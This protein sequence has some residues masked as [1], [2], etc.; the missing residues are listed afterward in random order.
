MPRYKVNISEGVF[1]FVEAESPDEA[2]KKVKAEIAKG[3]IS[4]FYDKLFFDYDTGVNVEGIRGKLGRAETLEEQDKVITNLMDKVKKRKLPQEQEDLMQTE[5][6]SAGFVRNTKGQL[7]LTPE[8]LRELGLT[9]NTTELEDGSII[10]QNTVIDERDFGLRTGDLAD[11]S[12]VA[13]PII[14]MLALMSPHLK[15]FKG[16]TSLFGGRQVISRMFAAGAGSVAGKGAEEVL[17][18]RQGFQLQDRDELANLLGGE[19]ILGSAGQGLGEGVF[20]IY[21]TFLGKRASHSSQRMNYQTTQ[22]RSVMDV[23]NLD[24]SLGREA[25]EKEI[26]RAVRDGE[27]KEFNWELNKSTGAIPSQQT[28]KRLIPARGQGIAE[29][30]IGNNR[31]IPNQQFLFA[32]LNY[33]LKGI[34]DE[35]SSLTSYISKTTKGD[36][37]ESISNALQDLRI[38][39]QTV[40]QS[41][42]K[43]LDDVSVDALEI[44]NYHNVPSR[45]ATGLAIKE[46]LG[47]A[48]R[49]VMEEMGVKYRDVDNMF[50]TMRSNKEMVID[51]FG[52]MIPKLDRNGQEI[53]KEGMNL[54]K[55]SY[56]NQ[57][58]G[59]IMGGHLE[60]AQ[61]RVRTFKNRHPMYR[62]SAAD[63]ELSGGLINTLDASLE[64]M[65][66]QARTGKLTLDQIRNSY[67]KLREITSTTAAQSPERKLIYE[68]MDM[69]DDY[70]K[71]GNPG[72]KPNSILTD[73]AEN[74][75]AQF[76]LKLARV[77]KDLP[78]DQRIKLNVSEVNTLNK[79][80]GQLRSANKLNFE[81]SSPF[82]AIDMDKIIAN[83]KKG[84]FNADE[85]YQSVIL[86]GKANRL[87]GIFAGLRSYDDYLKRIGKGDEAIFEN[88]VKSQIKKRLFAD[89]F[90]K[91]T[92]NGLEE[93]NFVDFAREINRFEKSYPGKFDLLFTN[94]NTGRNTGA[95]VRDTINQINRISPNLKPEQMRDLANDFTGKN[96]G[97]NASDQGTAFIQGLR[98]LATESEKVLKF[99][100]NKAI[101]D[102]PDKGI[103]ET[104]N[105]IFRPGSA[106]SINLLK[107]TVS[108]EV[109]NSVQQASM[110]K[111]LAKSIDFNGEGKITDI[112]KEGN[113]SMALKSYGDETLD[114][115][116]G[117]ELTQGLKGF[118][119]TVDNL[120]SGEVGRGGAAGGLVAAGIGAAIILNPLATLPV[121]ASLGILRMVFSSPK[122][123]GLLT[124]TDSGSIQQLI[125]MLERA[126]R[127]AGFRMIDGEFVQSASSGISEGVNLIKSELGKSQEE[128]KSIMNEG[129]DVFDDLQNQATKAVSIPL[130]DVQTTQ[131]PTA[132]LDPLSQDRIDFAERIGGRPIV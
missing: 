131:N 48:R 130:P 16:I 10:E 77:N 129:S 42:K 45:A 106:S 80:I 4:P 18:T 85:I 64:N 29:Q 47:K 49:S 94:S 14:G 123:V 52:E 97:L 51:E 132:S 17:D 54:K 53:L 30:L 59:D 50:V 41:L 27:V 9:V 111:L 61:R 128:I 126:A 55:A 122:F 100:A 101:S 3:A 88:K 115:M 6:G 87:D 39:E 74:T 23:M 89:A 20:K 113:L 91:S 28:L 79:S 102:L 69:L 8:G 7:A 65:I 107:E 99:K 57:A 26:A 37:D 15:V 78:V 46:T 108:P 84:A 112:F 31:D 25:T 114:A 63:D 43:L 75:E 34:K 76:N 24:K 33:I 60:R 56:L 5:V 105:S 95:A 21:Q 35:R 13:G 72:Y 44:G 116:F 110:Q 2:R 125:Q 19:F 104:V 103:E 40:T 22:N 38:K 119:K 121:I 82:D 124:K 118:Q 32:E 12:G 62:M 98:E 67:T 93:I 120:T 109:F 73:L 1:D 66:I 81:R 58:M 71:S 117:K 70:K 68:V 36:L 92:K 83:S 86:D 90:E 127:Q 11:M 96:V